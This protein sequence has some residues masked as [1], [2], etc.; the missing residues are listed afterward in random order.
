MRRDLASEAGTPGPRHCDRQRGHRVLGG[1][2]RTSGR[3]AERGVVA[4][5]RREPQAENT[6][7]YQN[8][9]SDLLFVMARAE[10]C[11]AGVSDIEWE[12]S[13]R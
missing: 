1:R 4:L 8:R 9:L 3:R 13:Q 12:G 7:R 5:H 6:L 2:S 10:N 11:R